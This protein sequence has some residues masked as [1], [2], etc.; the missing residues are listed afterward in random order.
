MTTDHDP[1]PSV[2]D[3]APAKTELDLNQFLPYRLNS[4][5]DRIS[6]ALAR[7]YEER[8]GIKVAEWRILAWLSHCDTLTA[9]KV[10]QY[11]GMDKARI[12][13]AIQ[14]LENRGLIHRT[15]S[16][17]DQRVHFLHLTAEGQ[18]LLDEL[19][20]LAHDWE[21]E[22]VSTLSTGEYRDLLHLMGKLDR[23]LTRLEERGD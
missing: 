8:F 13:R 23:Q 1:H 11:T 21:A 7:I 4:L 6:Q 16:A 22:L 17:E 3:P 18:A 5:A 14:A 15:P 12:S 2:H 10:G 19:I 9:K 20:P